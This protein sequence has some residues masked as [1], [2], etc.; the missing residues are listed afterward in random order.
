MKPAPPAELL[1]GPWALGLGPPLPLPR[2]TGCGPGSSPVLKLPW[3]TRASTTEQPAA[4]WQVQPAQPHLGGD[5]PRVEM[6][7]VSRSPA[8]QGHPCMRTCSCVSLLPLPQDMSAKV[9]PLAV[10]GTWY[11][12]PGL[13]TKRRLA[14]VGC[15]AGSRIRTATDRQGEDGGYKWTLRPQWRPRPPPPP[16]LITCGAPGDPSPHR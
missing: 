14:E 6:S 13:P 16:P 15:G 4:G 5:W 11:D 9:E 7:R 12:T 3:N 10:L 8:C 1:P 2:D